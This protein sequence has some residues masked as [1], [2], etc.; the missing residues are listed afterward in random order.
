[1]PV[2]FK[3]RRGRLAVGAIAM[4]VMATAA[5]CGGGGGGGESDNQITVWTLENLPDRMA[6]QKDIAE[7]FTKQ[8]GIKVKLVGVS[9]DQYSQ[10]LTSAAASGKLPDVIGALPLS[11]VRELSVNKLANTDV[12]QA[13]VDDLGPDT[14]SDQAL[15]LT[16]EGGQQLSVPSDAWAQLLVYRKD[17]FDKA[18]LPAPETYEDILA[19]AKKLDSDQVAGFVGAN[20]ADDAFTDQTFEHLALANDCQMVNDAKE[21]TLDTSNCVQAF[22]LYGDLLQNYSVPGTQ[23]VDTTRAT[24][25]AGKAAMVIW[26][27][28]IL[29]EMAGLRND[30]MP[31]CPECK[32]DPAYLAKTSGIVTALKGPSSS[33]PAQFGEVVSWAAT[34][35]AN[36]DASQKFIEYMMDQGYEDWIGFAPEGKIPTRQGTK[37][38]PTKF[39]DAWSELPAGVDKKAPLS[40][41]YDQKVLDALRSSPDTIQRWAL[42]QGAGALLGATLSEHPVAQAVNKVTTGEATPEEAAQQADEDV[43]S[44]QES[45]K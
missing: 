34:V 27:S 7:K 17:L 4:A 3:N 14:F 11:G 24:Y 42:P 22:Q 21:V 16:R 1:M 8:T 33:E 23:D 44:I 29:D 37:S 39:V 15:A 2:G 43:T 5:G 25:F 19:A 36:A 31:T 13:A 10:L 9:E 32:S 40:D 20:V 35:D 45:L 12:A 28:F 26:S 38:D 41:F 18:G 6:A 30:A